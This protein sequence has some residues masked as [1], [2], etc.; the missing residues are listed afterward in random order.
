LNLIFIL[1]LEVNEPKQ[2]SKKF[3]KDNNKGG[4]NKGRYDNNYD[5]DDDDDD[6]N[7]SSWSGISKFYKIQE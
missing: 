4:R 6:D 1:P 2:E 7:D 3:L 5:D